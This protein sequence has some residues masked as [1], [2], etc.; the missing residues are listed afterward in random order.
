ML[1]SSANRRARSVRSVLLTLLVFFCGAIP[2]FAATNRGHNGVK[3]KFHFQQTLIE[4]ANNNFHSPYSGKNS[5]LSRD[6]PAMSLTSNF[7][8]DLYLP[9]QF[10]AVFNPEMS[11]GE[12]LSGT[13]GLAAFPNGD[14]FRIGKPTPVFSSGEFYLVKTF[15]LTGRGLSSDETML[16][17]IAGKISLASYFDKNKY[18][19]DARTQFMN[20]ALMNNGAWDY[21]ADTRGYIPGVV[22]E[23]LSPI[24]TFRFA[25]TMQTSSAN[26]PSYDP[27]IARAHSFNLQGGYAYR[28]GDRRGKVR[29]LLY[30]NTGHFGNYAEATNDPQYNHNIALTRQ[31]GRTKVGFGINFQQSL[32]RN[33]GLFARIGWNDGQNESWSYTEIDRTVSAGILTK[34][35]FFG[36]KHDAFGIGIAVDGISK[37][38]RQ[39]LASGG[40]GF[41]I[42]DGKLP[43][44][45]PAEV[46]ETFYRFQLNKMLALSADYQYIVN[47][48]YNPQRGPVNVFGIRAHVSI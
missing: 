20:W 1:L 37:A 25:A 8:F 24:F 13:V 44:Y 7:H 10:R 35:E 9:D 31:Y 27:N 6:R 2:S 36:R 15:G 40:Y 16:T 3:L 38:H 48:A 19:N 46:L 34:P 18:S 41:I 21:A 12:A 22:A 32:C 26:G 5:F 33:T 30:Y 42:G 4:Q 14:A 23:Y 29:L 39:Y 43:Q 47:P 45:A 28:L 17:I 11:G